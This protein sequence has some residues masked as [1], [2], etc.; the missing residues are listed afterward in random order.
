M[1]GQF[2]DSEAEKLYNLLK[3]IP[4]LQGDNLKPSDYVVDT[5]ILAL[6]NFLKYDGF[7]EILVEML[8]QQD[9]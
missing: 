8:I 3:S 2:R 1:D 4:T 5:L 9:L 7:E 6:M